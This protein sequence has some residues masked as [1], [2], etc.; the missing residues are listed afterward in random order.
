MDSPTA[1]DRG[2]NAIEAS[3]FGFPV[4]TLFNSCLNDV[5]Q[6][7]KIFLQVRI[8]AGKEKVL[9][10]I[11]ILFLWTAAPGLHVLQVLLQET[12]RVS[13]A[14]LSGTFQRGCCRIELE[15]F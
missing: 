13:I 15:I 4:G 12:D 7:R 14:F 2:R 1:N 9:F 11:T 6:E 10:A 3:C 8:T 5:V